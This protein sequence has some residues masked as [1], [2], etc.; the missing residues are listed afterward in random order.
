MTIKTI[1]KTIYLGFKENKT[2]LYSATLTY[3]TLLAIVP[4]FALFLL[5]AE[6]FHFEAI[7][8]DWLLNYFA[9]Q[10]D[11]AHYLI[12]FAHHSFETTHSTALKIF[13]LL[14][15][16]WAT[17][18][19]LIYID[20]SINHIWHKQFKP[21]FL[22]RNAK[23]LIMFLAC[24]LLFIIASGLSFSLTS[25]FHYINKEAIFSEKIAH[26]IFIISNLF[27]SLITFL[28]LSFLY[29]FVPYA[30][31]S[32]KHAFITGLVTSMVYQLIQYGF[33]NLQILLSSYSAIYGT[34]AAF[35]LFL[36]W[37]H[38]SWV[39][40]LIG[41]KLCFSLSKNKS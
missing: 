7:L 20:I 34:F 11:I 25:L 15:L 6:R 8:Q 21:K 37:L 2:Q 5:I 1:A 30:K 36:V 12:S 35:P 27:P 18:K 24:P 16:L 31:I 38:L 32:L 29:Y 26:T 13:E 23:F 19:M 10:P 17:I 9:E 4:I 39:I 40:F 14:L 41:A 28:L 3:Y 22:L 33:F